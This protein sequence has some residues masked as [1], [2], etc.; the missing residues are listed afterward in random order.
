MRDYL[1]L[2]YPFIFQI[3]WLATRHRVPAISL[4]LVLLCTF[5]CTDNDANDPQKWIEE[6]AKDEYP[7][8]RLIDLYAESVLP[9]YE[10]V[11]AWIMA[12][13]FTKKALQGRNTGYQF[14]TALL[15]EG[16]EDS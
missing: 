2:L 14:D 1:G 5:S 15:H 9:E 10:P 11:D 6:A 4:A 8:S 13:T 7:H 12:E 3:K 16:V